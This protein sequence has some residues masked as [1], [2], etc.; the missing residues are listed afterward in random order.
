MDYAGIIPRQAFTLD[1]ELPQFALTGSKSVRSLV[2]DTT[3]GMGFWNQRPKIMDSWTLWG[4]FGPSKNK[5]LGQ[6]CSVEL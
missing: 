4:S 2:P 6:L 3:T 5:G 1:L